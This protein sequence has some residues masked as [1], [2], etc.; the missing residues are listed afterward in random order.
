MPPWRRGRRS[1]C[2]ADLLDVEG[3]QVALY[4]QDVAHGGGALDRPGPKHRLWMVE[5]GW[6]YERAF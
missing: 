5:S 2:W 4:H 3:G 6:R 1:V